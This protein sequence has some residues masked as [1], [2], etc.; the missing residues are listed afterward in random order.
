MKTIKLLLAFMAFIAVKTNAQ[1]GVLV[2]SPAETYAVN[3]AT[4]TRVNSVVT[5]S[6]DIQSGSDAERS[7][8]FSKT[9]SVD[10]GD[11]I[12]LNNQYGSMVIKTWDRKEVK[13]D[14]EIKA[15]SNSDKDVQKLIDEVSIDANKTG[16]LV[17]V[18]TN[19]NDGNG[20]YGRKSRNG[21][22]T[23]RR[24]IKVNY[25]VYMPAAN[26]LTAQQQYG[27]IDLGDFSGPTSLK[28]QYG[29]LTAGNLSSTN[30]YLYVEYGKM[31]VQS[32]N[33]AVV[34][35]EYGGGI[36]IGSVGTLQLDAEY[37]PVNVNTISKSANIKIQYGAGLTVGSI[38]GNLLLNSEYA[39]V[40]INSIKGN[41]VI[42]QSYSSLTLASVGKLSLKTEYTNVTLG[43]LNGD[44]IIDMDYNRLSVNEITAAC[45]NFNFTGE[46]ASVGLGF[47]DNYNANF[48][49][50]T[51][52]AGFK[53]GSNVTS[54][55]V[56]DDDE[57]KRYTGKI[58]NGGSSTL[59]LKTE[60]GAVTFK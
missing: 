33:T 21:V 46:Y 19:M 56:S 40:N 59:S 24:E 12:S 27:S 57:N 53:Y 10:N 15:Y 13:V 34:K 47:S 31:T 7:K 54:K 28:V 6:N 30:N 44:A 41:T 23:W 43:S 16:D 51:T 17:S 4:S 37:V 58:G 1:Q 29:N 3:S 52:Y 39:K 26:A 50:S 25:V 2:S 5:S 14:V 42:K 22:T 49:I 38:G 20:N 60:Y 8:N 9:F 35:H 45:K 36:S 11:K 48:N 18:K 32:L 55:L